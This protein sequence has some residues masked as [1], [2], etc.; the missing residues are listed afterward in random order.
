MDRKNATVLFLSMFVTE[1]G[2][3]NSYF[4]VKSK[5]VTFS[6]CPCIDTPQPIK[7]GS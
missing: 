1:Y 7:D 4:N 2:K 3:D 6:V 5:I